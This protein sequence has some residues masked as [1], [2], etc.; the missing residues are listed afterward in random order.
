MIFTGRD[1]TILMYTIAN[2]THKIIN[3]DDEDL[4][5]NLGLRWDKKGD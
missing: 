1:M 5:K 3:R 2:T 4:Q